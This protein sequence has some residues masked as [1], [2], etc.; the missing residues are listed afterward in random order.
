MKHYTVT[1]P[2]GYVLCLLGR[3]VADFLSKQPQYR[4]RVRV[5]NGL[6]W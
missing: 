5:A 4:G 3:Q 1:T 2:S 6:W